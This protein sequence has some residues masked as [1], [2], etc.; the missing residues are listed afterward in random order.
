MEKEKDQK[1]IEL[2]VG[3][4]RTSSNTVTIGNFTV[5][6]KQILKHFN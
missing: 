5:S 3:F 1:T 6:E 2:N 4:Y